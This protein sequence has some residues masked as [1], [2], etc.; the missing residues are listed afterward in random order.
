MYR[1]L[2][3][4]LSVLNPRQR[5][6]FFVINFF[7]FIAS[8]L[9]MLSIVVVLPVA[10]I[11]TDEE[12]IFEEYPMLSFLKNYEIFNSSEIEK[13]LVFFMF[14]I[15][16]IFLTKNLILILIYYI[17]EKYFFNVR[18][19]VMNR[20]YL[21]YIYQSYTSRS[22]KNSSLFINNIINESALLI[23]MG[24][25]NYVNF[26]QEMSLI[27]VITIF[28]LNLNIYVTLGSILFLLILFII[29]YLPVKKIIKKFSIL[30]QENEEKRIKDLNETFENF[31]YIKILSL[32]PFFSKVFSIQNT[33]INKALYIFSF[34]AILPIKFFETSLIVGL[35][36]I[37]F[38]LSNNGYKIGDVTTI[39][40]AFS[41]CGLRILPSLNRIFLYLQS[42]KFSYPAI[43]KVYNDLISSIEFN[44]KNNQK[45]NNFNELNIKIKQFNYSEKD[46]L[47]E[48]VDL[49][50]EKGNK[51]FLKGPT[52][53][54][55]SSLINLITGL[56]VD[57]K[58]QIKINKVSIR[59]YEDKVY[60]KIN[61]GFVPQEIFLS[62]ISL[63]EN[64]VLNNE[65]NRSKF[66]K[67]ISICELDKLIKNLKNREN[68]IIDQNSSNI[69]G[70]QKQRIAIAR[71]LMSDCQILILDEATN[72]LDPETE[73]KIIENI[74]TNYPD[75]AIIMIS[76][77]DNI[78]KYCDY[79][80]EIKNKQ[81]IQYKR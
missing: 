69:S 27:I 53:S 16:V 64:I 65:F 21:K 24:I 77:K 32:E 31:K 5:F 48:N 44:S 3:K 80:Y 33:I 43:D 72:A 38:F 40:L 28:L 23:D 71:A 59:N 49:L 18:S 62:N 9:E 56:T 42:V 1:Y 11:I 52:G 60:Q 15:G 76:H 54:G 67:I 47:F 12:G 8:I 50:I 41:L 61:F 37:C 13:I 66:N 78:E 73:K 70:G 39:L 26:F 75:L 58:V 55:K 79:V 20:V 10:R 45:L 34:I 19:Y 14:I 17:K 2:K 57:K 51:I 46:S 22:N 30:R 63:K 6:Y 81:I 35:F 25:K 74:I 68:E 7:L 29:I 4:I 36:L